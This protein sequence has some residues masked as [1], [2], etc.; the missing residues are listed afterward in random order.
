MR[1][2]ILPKLLP[3]LGMVVAAVVVATM[4]ERVGPSLRDSIGFV[5]LVEVLFC[6]AQGTLTDIATRLKKPPPLWL[7]LLILGGLALFNPDVVSVV[8]GMFRQGWAIFLPFAWSLVERARELWT[9][10]RASQLEKLRRRALTSGR[11]SLVL[12]FGGA[13]VAT[14]CVGY[15]LDHGR[16]GAPL[17]ER[18]AFWW[19][20]AAFSLTAYDVVRVHRPAF[21]RHPRALFGRFDPLGVTDLAPV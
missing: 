3:E 1:T 18:T 2:D 5:A 8:V 16:G 4:P 19:L 7:G 20:A 12:V 17:L 21:E 9:M 10:P 11:I 13:A 14:L 15:F 6:M